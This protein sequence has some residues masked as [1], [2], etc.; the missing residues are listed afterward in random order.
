MNFTTNIL[1]AAT[2]STHLCP[3]LLPTTRYSAG[4]SL[5]A[6]T[7]AIAG[8]WGE[9]MMR[10][11]KTLA[12]DFI[13]AS[14]AKRNRLR[15]PVPASC[16]LL[17]L[18]MIVSTCFDDFFILLLLNILGIPVGCGEHYA[19]PSQQHQHP[20]TP[21]PSPLA[22]KRQRLASSSQQLHETL[23][24]TSDPPSSV[25]PYSLPDT[26]D[27]ELQSYAIAKQA[28]EKQQADS[29]MAMSYAR[30]LKS[31]EDFWNKRNHAG[32]LSSAAYVPVEPHPIVASKV[33]VFL[34]YEMHRTKVSFLN[35][36]HVFGSQN[37]LA[38]T[39]GPGWLRGDECRPF[40]NTASH[41]C[42]REC[43]EG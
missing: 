29:Q 26:E 2:A 23:A 24:P 20:L 13:S 34:D 8:S 22:R 41:L 1:H 35:T 17:V 30:H 12:M 38:Q 9:S 11:Y 33:C 36:L 5:R 10:N 40:V 7:R 42:T 18:G 27:V 31:Y 21:T 39:R 15:L 14:I 43:S 16:K 37:S 4:P 28:R 32:Q 19:L 25:L 6:R 3:L